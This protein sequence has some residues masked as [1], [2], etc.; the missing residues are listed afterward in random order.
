MRTPEDLPPLFVCEP[1]TPCRNVCV[2][3]MGQDGR[4]RAAEL[5]IESDDSDEEIARAIEDA[6]REPASRGG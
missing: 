3:W 5:N 1:M 6:L 2:R 4:M